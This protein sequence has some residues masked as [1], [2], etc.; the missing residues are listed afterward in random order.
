MRRLDVCLSL[1]IILVALCT[2]CQ[3]DEPEPSATPAPS[4][5][6]ASAPPTDVPATAS[7]TSRP[8]AM[9]PSMQEPTSA[10]AAGACVWQVM[11]RPQAIPESSYPSVN[12]WGQDRRGRL[13]VGSNHGLFTIVLSDLVDPGPDWLQVGP[14]GIVDDWILDLAIDADDG[15][16]YCSWRPSPRASR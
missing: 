6:A 13:W 16:R 10:P 1:L 5:T 3:S 8:S 14:E 11:P 15:V 4:R 2:A 9:P 7:P 12:A